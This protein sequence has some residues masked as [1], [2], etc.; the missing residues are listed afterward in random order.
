MWVFTVFLFFSFF[1]LVGDYLLRWWR[2]ICILKPVNI[3]CITVVTVLSSS[4]FESNGTKRIRRL[5][6]VEIK[7][8]P[9]YNSSFF[10]L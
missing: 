2:W 9:T 8:G 3:P 1:T 6:E 4:G 5:F 10:F 7:K